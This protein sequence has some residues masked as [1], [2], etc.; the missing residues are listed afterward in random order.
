MN[1]KNIYNLNWSEAIYNL[2]WSKLKNKKIIITRHGQSIKNII[3]FEEQPMYIRLN[4]MTS[5][6]EFPLTDLGIE[7][8]KSTGLRIKNYLKNNNLEITS[9]YQS[10]HIRT[11]ETLKY[12]LESISSNYN[13]EDAITD[14]NLN[15]RNHGIWH[16]LTDDEIKSMYPGEHDI[17]ERM[18]YFNYSAP[19]GENCYGVGSR[20][21]NFFNQLLD[22][23]L[24]EEN[25]IFIASHGRWMQILIHFLKN[26]SEEN[27]NNVTVKESIKNCSLLCLRYEDKLIHEFI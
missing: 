23:D 27:F 20:I 24:S 14:G 8:A 11:H 12:V 19:E 1:S 6:K 5:D 4:N 10:E 26:E 22:N 18:G 25:V 15:E 2:N 3:S 17:K 16:H 9:F 13:I 21:Y 7:Q